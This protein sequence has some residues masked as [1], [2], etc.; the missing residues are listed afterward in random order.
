[1]METTILLTDTHF[2]T[3]QNSITWFKAQKAF[4]TDQL[5]PYIRSQEHPIRVIHLGDVFDSRMT[6]STYIATEVVELFKEIRSTVDEFI[7]IGGNH[8][9]YSPNTDRID[10]LRLI[11]N[12]LD[13]RLVTQDIYISGED[14]F[15]PWYRWFERKDIDFKGIR[16]V[17]THADIVTA[18]H[19]IALPKDIHIYSGHTHTPKLVNNL[20]NLGSCYCLDFNDSNAAR[21]FYVLRDGTLEFIKNVTSIRFYRLHDD[22][23]FKFEVD[24]IRHNDYIELYI[25][26]SNLQ[27]DEYITRISEITK[28][29]KNSWIIPNIAVVEGSHEDIDIHKYNIEDLIGTL[30]PEHLKDKFEDVKDSIGDKGGA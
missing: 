24:P 16:N 26:R 21:G 18:P 30:I 9:Y 11:L 27:R 20:Y 5:L 14:M 25:T 6:I 8:D 2:G 13:I 10:S 19:D 4:I 7:V 23:I 22:E 17:F 29:Y 12:N 3:K 15:I 1:M 28:T